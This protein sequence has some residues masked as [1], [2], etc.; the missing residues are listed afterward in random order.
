MLS[1]LTTI[2][3][4]TSLSHGET[5]LLKSLNKSQLCFILAHPEIPFCIKAEDLVLPKLRS[6][7]RFKRLA[8]TAVGG[9]HKEPRLCPCHHWQNYSVA[10]GWDPSFP[11]DARRLWRS[12]VLL[13]REE[14]AHPAPALTAELRTM[15]VWGER[16]GERGIP[17]KRH[18]VSNP[19]SN[20]NIP[21]NFPFSKIFIRWNS[22]DQHIASSFLFL[23]CFETASHSSEWDSSECLSSKASHAEIIGTCH[24]FYFILTLRNSRYFPA[25]EEVWQPPGSSPSPPWRTVPLVKTI[26][27]K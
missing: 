15:C 11:S 14:C 20:L 12:P 3:P 4:G 24:H 26:N 10:S 22:I 2:F 8:R 6:L 27:Q 5:L 18:L 9:G 16:G 25:A 17:G 1:C 13:Y 19:L 23:F 21:F 7:K